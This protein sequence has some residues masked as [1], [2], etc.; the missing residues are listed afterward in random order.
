MFSDLSIVC[1][2]EDGQQ[3]E[4]AFKGWK[5]SIDVTVNWNLRHLRK[6]QFTRKLDGIAFYLTVC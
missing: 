2:N 3:G 6:T 1:T 4:G 5:M